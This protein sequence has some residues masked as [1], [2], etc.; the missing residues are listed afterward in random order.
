ALRTP[1]GALGVAVSVFTSPPR[2]ISRLRMH[3]KVLA[4]AY[5]ELSAPRLGQAQVLG[6]AH[7][8][9]GAV[10]AGRHCAV[11]LVDES[12]LPDGWR[13]EEPPERR[14]GAKPARPRTGAIASGRG[15]PAV[16]RE[17][18]SR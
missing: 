17:A 13:K 15:S 12:L 1:R 8:D 10:V 14:D 11:A 3:R 7:P 2:T 6:R 16:R 5:S 18:R 4:F 9:R